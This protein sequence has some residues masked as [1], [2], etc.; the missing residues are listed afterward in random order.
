MAYATVD[1]L[2][3][4]WR[5]LSADEQT[6]AETLLED[7]GVYL[8]A[9]LTKHHLTAD[10]KEKLLNMISCRLV[11]VRLANRDDGVTQVSRTAGSFN[12]QYTLVNPYGNFQLTSDERDLL[13]IARSGK[14]AQIGPT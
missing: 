1:D 14:I 5:E 12:E 6:R 2:A 7:A 10:G 13:G 11:Q 8:D 9:V 3:K 4:R